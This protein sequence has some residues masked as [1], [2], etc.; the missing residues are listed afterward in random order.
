[1]VNP[2][3]WCKRSNPGP[4]AIDYPF[5]DSNI[6]LTSTRLDGWLS[7]TFSLMVLSE[8]MSRLAIEGSKE[9]VAI[10]VNGSI[11][12]ESEADRQRYL[13]NRDI[14]WDVYYG[15]SEISPPSLK[16]FFLVFLRY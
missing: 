8:A 5:L 7:L 11:I 6:F 9:L 12:V 15:H 4:A 14:Y 2:F 10:T 16:F 13:R 3:Y 1:M